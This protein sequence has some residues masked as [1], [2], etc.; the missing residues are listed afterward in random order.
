MES[1]PYRSLNLPSETRVLTVQPGKFEDEIQCSLSHIA[2]AAPEEPYEA[3]S[4]C[5]SKGVDRDPADNGIGPDTEIPWAVYG[6]D[7]NG[8]EFS[9]SGT[10]PWK[11][12]VDHPYYHESYIR[13]GGKMP[14]APITCDGVRL[15]VGGELFRALRRLRPEEGPPLRIWVDA[16]CINQQD[17]AERNEHVK[18][19]GR[20]YAG[21]SGTRV[22]LGES[23]QFDYLAF[24]TLVAVSELL[25]DILIKR[26]LPERGASMQEIQWHFTNSP[27]P[28][29]LDWGLLSEM[30][31]RAW[32]RRTWII[33]E[34][35]NS[36]KIKVHIG[37]LS[38]SWDFFAAVICGIMNFKLQATISECKAFKAV[39]IM[40]QLRS[41][42]VGNSMAPPAK[43]PF[44]DLLEELRDFQA[45]LPSDKIYS[46]LGLTEHRDELVVDYAQSPEK[47]FIDIAVKELRTGS[48]DILAHCVDSSKPTL[49]ALPSWV[50]DWTRPGWTEPL[51]IRGL[52]SAAAGDTKPELSID[53]GAGILKIRGRLL[54]RIAAVEMK[55]Q[56]P[57]PK[58]MGPMDADDNPDKEEFS[59]A[60]F[61]RQ[62]PDAAE[63]DVEEEGSSVG[64]E[65]PSSESPDRKKKRPNDVKYRMARIAE[66][67]KQSAKDWYTGVADVAFPEKKATPQTLENLW[68]TFM[69]N[70][71][72][73]NERPGENCAV[74]MDIHYKVV[75]DA[76]KGPAGVLQERVDH[77]IA[78]HGLSLRDADTYY[79]REKK[80][81][82]TF[83]GGHT[84]WTYNR[85]FF[86]TDEG[87][88]GCCVDGTEPGDEV[89]LFYGCDS[90]FV[91]RDTD[92][93]NGKKR[94][95]GDCYIHGL[96]DGE[97]LA[98]QF[99]EVEF[100]LA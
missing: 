72:R 53:L 88:F 93:G 66:Q 65:G 70:R 51:S 14:D 24:D 82:E 7:D 27:N 85:R 75:L 16:L 8:E 68:R 73:E 6:R 29:R 91:L 45:T 47:V 83:F 5:W 71:T 18:I 2:I 80:S 4:Y 56:I 21:A 39:G 94:I 1:Y 44:L 25:D 64:Q 97:G 59:M 32:F 84:K 90:A 62:I 37:G 77:Q 48:L 52:Q 10:S 89:V 12:L 79:L 67:V 98:R 13:L 15:V 74:G 33:Q 92:N 86:R 11:D 46:I 19:M 42:R 60:Q 57:P 49:L 55:R 81:F 96:V 17:I 35:A 54:D 69:C 3:L 26:G 78:S 61:G 95:I 87:R 31:N 100:Q 50:P 20:I 63:E 58:Q 76:D 99:Q 9:K 38:F 41:E 22:W 28:E 23:T 40:E 36:K 43:I 34:V 30:L